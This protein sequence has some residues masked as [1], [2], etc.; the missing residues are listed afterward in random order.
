MCK[1]EV[2]RNQSTLK[3]SSANTMIKIMIN[4]LSEVDWPWKQARWVKGIPDVLLP[5]T[6]NSGTALGSSSSLSCPENLQLEA[7]WH[8][9]LLAP[10]SLFKADSNHPVGEMHFGSFCSG[11]Y[12]DLMIMGEGW[13]V[14]RL[15]NESF[16]FW[17]GSLFTV[18]LWYISYITAKT[19]A[20]LL[21][22]L[23]VLHVP[24]TCE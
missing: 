23:H 21:V 15:L 2:K 4:C 17:P 13:D 24:I 10:Y 5:L 12:Q 20:D 18:T 7:L 19:V 8:P 1:T 14:D 11:H 6:V 16:A 9:D 3:D 22:Q